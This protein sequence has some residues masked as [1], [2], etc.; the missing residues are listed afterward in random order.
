MHSRWRVALLIFAAAISLAA[1]GRLAPIPQDLSYHN[2]VDSRSFLQIP[3]FLNVA[4]NLPFLV[5]W[6]L[7]LA[8][9]R[10]S[11]PARIAW[12]AMFLGVMMVAFGSGYYHLSPSSAA[13][14]WD[15]FPMAVGFMGLLV[16]LLTEYVN[17]KLERYLL[18]PAILIGV[19]S[20]L[21]WHLTNDLRFYLWV[22]FFPFLVLLFLMFGMRGRDRIY[23]LAAIG[24]YSLAK[25]TEIY[26]TESFSL[27]M[28][29]IS[30]HSIKHLLA[31]SG[32]YA[33]YQM[34]RPDPTRKEQTG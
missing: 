24:F 4:T 12:S 20:V 19:S 21:Y 16:A 9:T 14:V 10:S 17:P 11:R 22:Q 30:G 32:A 27:T 29:M 7:G 2:F 31:A 26:D 18:M 13:L 25:I 5:V 8:A 3:N 34:V 15:R 6:I 28:G 33:I 23:L 1:V